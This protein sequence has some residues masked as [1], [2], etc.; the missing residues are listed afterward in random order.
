[1]SCMSWARVAESAPFMI[2]PVSEG[3]AFTYDRRSDDD[4]PCNDV[5][6]FVD[7]AFVG[8]GGSAD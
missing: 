6:S 5:K 3:C 7:S 2:R 1:M 8:G 4:I